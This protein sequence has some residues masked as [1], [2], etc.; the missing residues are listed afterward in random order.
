MLD[1]ALVDNYVY[2]L[3][4]LRIGSYAPDIY[5]SLYNRNIIACDNTCVCILSA[6]RDHT[7]LSEINAF[8]LYCMF[9][10]M[11]YCKSKMMQCLFTLTTPCVHLYKMHAPLTGFF[12]G[13][14]VNLVSH[15]S[16]VHSQTFPMIFFKPNSFCSGNSVT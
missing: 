3:A 10:Q 6:Y 1:K 11:I 14:G 12:L 16:W 7:C 5:N 15:Q 8:P 4:Y 2:T 13:V 9:Q